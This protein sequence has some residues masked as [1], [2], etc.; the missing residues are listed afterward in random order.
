M[1]LLTGL[2]DPKSG[3]GFIENAD[4]QTLLSG[5]MLTCL[6]QAGDRA[7]GPQRGHE[8][9]VLLAQLGSHTALQPFTRLP[10][11]GHNFD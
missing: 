1:H 11:T 10:K 7:V 2:S 3:L 9:E 5:Q 4:G 8:K 6:E